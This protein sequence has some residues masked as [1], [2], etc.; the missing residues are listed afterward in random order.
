MGVVCNVIKDVK[1]VLG[2]GVLEMVVVV[3]LK[4]KSM[5]IEGVE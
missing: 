2:G 3:I 4:K 5:L 1:L